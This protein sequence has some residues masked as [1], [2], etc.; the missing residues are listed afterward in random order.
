MKLQ[1]KVAL[2]F[3]RSDLDAMQAKVRAAATEAG[4]DSD[5]IIY[6]VYAIEEIG[7]NV[8][9]HSG[10]S[11]ME[12]RFEPT[13][14]GAELSFLDDGEE[15][16]PVESAGYLDEPVVSEYVSGHLGLWTLKQ[17]PFRQTWA[18]EGGVNHLR[19]SAKKP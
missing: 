16:D 14:E 18:R 7:A 11:W 12:I 4:F 3:E 19:F 8:L 6:L 1:L 13:P 10:A 15:F 2:P 9:V 5:T 17:M